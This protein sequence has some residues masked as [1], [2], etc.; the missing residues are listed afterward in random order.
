MTADVAGWRRILW[1]VLPG[2]FFPVPVPECSG[3]LFTIV[4][5]ITTC[6]PWCYKN[7]GV[8]AISSYLFVG[9]RIPP[10]HLNYDDFL[11]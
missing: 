11:E 5:L 9:G 4:K 3:I 2:M 6:L 7:M 1:M 10:E 8:A